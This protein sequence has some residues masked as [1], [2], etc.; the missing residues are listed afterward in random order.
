MNDKVRQAL[1]LIADE[2]RGMSAIGGYFAVNPYEV[3]RANRIQALAV[4]L[5]ALADADHTLDEIQAIFD[6][7]PWHR[8]SPFVG[9]EMVVLDAEGQLLLIQ[10][11]QD[12]T[13]AMPG[14][15]AEVG[16]SPAEAAMR[17]L[18]E[19]AGLR[20]Q[21]QRLLGVFDG[22]RW[23]SRAVVH[24]IT[25]VFH[26]HCPQLTPSTGLETLAA[27]FFPV[28]A[29]PQPLYPGHEQRIPKALE[30]LDTGQTYFDPAD[31]LYGALPM[32]QRPDTD[33]SNSHHKR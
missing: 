30:M 18:W 19:E 26:I 23:G 32:T 20:G 11:A 33:E 2:M 28:D 1:Y 8:F 15:L 21:A 17:E 13:W 24:G 6:K 5:A 29:L 27:D 22:P 25:L 3:E 16:Q 10:R 14:G 9:V 4:K 7:Q 12:G 31:T